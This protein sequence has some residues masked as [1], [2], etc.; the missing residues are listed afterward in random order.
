MCLR[1]CSTR[2]VRHVIPIERHIRLGTADIG[3]VE[4]WGLPYAAESV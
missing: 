3:D 1:T 2:T 4:E